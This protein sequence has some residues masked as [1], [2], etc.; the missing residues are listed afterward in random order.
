MKVAYFSPLNPQ[1]SG[2]S[3]YSEELL[4]HLKKYLD[5]HLFIDG[6][7]LSNKVIKEKFP[8]FNIKEFEYQ[9]A[10]NK[11]KACIYHIGN[12]HQFH[13]NI[14]LHALKYAGIVIMHDYAIH[15]LMAGMLLQKGKTAEYLE[16]IRY[17]NGEEGAKEAQK[18]LK[19]EIAPLWETSSIDY[20]MNKRIINSARGIIVH[21]KFVQRLINKIRPDVPIRVIP[22]HCANILENPDEAKAVAR[23]ILGVDIKTI[24]L[25]SFGHIVPAKRIDTV[26][27]A[28]KRL[29]N[30]YP[31]FIYYLIGEQAKGYNL[32]SLVKEL[33]LSNK[34]IF[35][36]YTD[37]GTFKEYMKATDICI[38]LRYPI[39]GETSGSLLR[40]MGMGKPVVVSNVGSFAELP[41]GTVEKIDVDDT[42]EDQL[43]QV[44]RKF[45]KNLSLIQEV[46]EKALGYVKS[47]CSLENSAFRYSN[48]VEE[49][50]NIQGELETI[51]AQKIIREIA[52][53]MAQI[54]VIKYNNDLIY[55]FANLLNEIGIT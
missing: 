51:S 19:G 24:V 2:I 50:V 13:E 47:N 34:V 40:L 52:K 54:G 27:R 48:F 28:L 7:K 37:L 17:N 14:Y 3:D 1:K 5:I 36:G 12:N 32:K 55:K 11:Y 4:L 35:T 45:F 22:H 23:K 30:E 18:S 43:V 33:G 20:P 25:A 38:N 16:E 26:L 49:V 39:Q 15:H 31:D 8:I 41:L 9:H 44:L 42:E 53:D 10:K 46:G 29:S 6:F 21:S